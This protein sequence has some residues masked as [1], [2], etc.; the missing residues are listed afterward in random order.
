MPSN[1]EEEATRIYV[2]V[3]DFLKTHPAKS[4][5]VCKITEGV[6]AASLNEIVSSSESLGR[7]SRRML[8]S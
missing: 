1:I 3:D 6:H 7:I 4:R 5:M 2:F 8:L